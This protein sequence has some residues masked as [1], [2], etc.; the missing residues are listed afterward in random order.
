MRT[1][2]FAVV[3]LIAT[4]GAWG[5][6]STDSLFTNPEPDSVA[7]T[8][9]KV[10][11]DPFNG[12][13]LTFFETFTVDGYYIGGYRD[14]GTEVNT[15]VD[16]LNFGF[17]TDFR[18]D[19]STRAYAS[20][21]LSY[22]TQTTT[23]TDLYNPYQL[24]VDY[25]TSTASFSTI[26]VK[27][28]FIDYS[29]GDAAIFRVG[30]QTGTWGQGKIFNPGN[31]I[32]GI[33]NG[34]AAKM[35]TS[36]GSVNLTA[37]TIKNDSE[38]D[39]TSGTELAASLL[40]LGDAVLAEYSASL[41][42]VGVSGFYNYNVGG[43]LDAYAKTSLYG[44]DL[45]VEVLGEHG[46]HL[47]QTV[48]GVAGFYHEFGSDTKWLKLETEWL[49]SGRGNSGTF[50]S[51]TDQNLGFSDQSLGIAA[52]SEY[53]NPISLKPSL[54]WLQSFA[55]GSGQVIL[56]FESTALPHIDL[57]MALT[58]VYGASGTRYIANNPDSEDRTWSITLK[59]SFNFDI[60]SS[61]NKS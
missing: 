30:R 20:L 36:I 2:F 51:V 10:S 3:A 14:D 37:V 55:D 46:T 12:R 34:I 8:T 53:F 38:Y 44:T 54:A 19:R 57:T 56:G 27:E 23:T 42:S 35:S 45:F 22:P 5:D 9:K 4:C 17:G 24:D 7:D 31:L 11:V 50:A 21:Y 25:S 32:D 18:L 29:L 47:E 60:K 40:S 28:M 26:L 15:P 59:A 16:A 6:D 41:F 43:K 61:D 49:V 58:R 52:S 13:S 33:G 48:T 39:I 1:C